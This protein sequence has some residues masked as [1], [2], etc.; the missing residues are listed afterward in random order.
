MKT[1][2]IYCRQSIDKLDSVSIEAQ[3]E[4][5]KR[6]L[7][8]DN[9]E[10]YFDKGWSGKHISRP[11]MNQLVQDIKNDKISKVIAYRLDRISRNIVDFGN[12]LTL[13]SEYNVDFASATENFDTSTPIGRAMVY[14]VMVFA[15]LERET[16]AARI[17]DNYKFRSS[18]GK[19]FM[20]GNVPFGYE[21]QKAIV[22]GKKA[23]IIV[24]DEN[25]AKI[26]EDIFDAFI[27]GESLYNIAHKLNINGIRTASNKMFYENA[28]RRI[29][30]NITPCAADEKIYNYLFSLG[31]KISN[32]VEDFT[33]DN[34]M[35]IFF[36]NKNRNEENDISEHV[37]VV[38]I[39]KPIIQ[40]EKYIRAQILLGKNSKTMSKKRSKQ[41]FLAGLCTCVECGKSFGLKSSS[42]YKYYCCRGRQ[43]TGMCNNRLYIRADEFE[44]AVI[45]QCINYLNQFSHTKEEVELEQIP[46]NTNSI[47]LIEQQIA[48]L[49]ENI[50]KGNSVVDE[51]LTNKITSLQ[52]QIDSFRVEKEKEIVGKVEAREIND[53][54]SIFQDFD[55]LDID[56]KILNIRKIVKNIEITKDEEVKIYYLIKP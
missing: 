53:L 34:G 40:S 12:L 55:S 6:Y 26:L 44:K 19:Y 22:D 7:D 24:P 4:Q 46:D 17:K 36:K 10:V 9:Y 25:N 32:P 21:S 33:G 28:I 8:S 54:K 47:A 1:I 29:L 31:Y 42:R 14:I 20:G 50:G 49:I 18:T 37:V 23:S 3:I 2:A 56:K 35:C 52:N 48:N 27:A 41:S 45:E 39:H 43:T 38:G 16:I 15:Q 30:Q 5:C 13:F 11:K 51:L